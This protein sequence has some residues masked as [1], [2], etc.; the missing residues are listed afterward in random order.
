VKAIWKSQPA[1]PPGSRGFENLEN[2]RPLECASCSCI[3]VAGKS[4]ASRAS[5]VGSWHR[6]QPRRQ[7]SACFGSDQKTGLFKKIE[8]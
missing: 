4:S 2:L 5:S 3:L 8:E 7:R 1:R 6:R